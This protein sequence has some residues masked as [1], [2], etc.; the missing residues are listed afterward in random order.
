MNILILDDELD[1]MSLFLQRLRGFADNVI[2]FGSI[3]AAQQY[4]D[5]HFMLIDLFLIDETLD[6]ASDGP[7]ERSGSLFGKSIAEKYPYIPLILYTGTSYN[8]MLAKEIWAKYGF[9]YIVDKGHF[10]EDIKGHLDEFSRFVNINQQWKYREERR[11]EA[12]LRYFTK[13]TPEERRKFK[14]EAEKYAPDW[15]QFQIKCDDVEFSLANLLKSPIIEQDATERIDEYLRRTRRKYAF[16]GD[17]CGTTIETKLEKYLDLP[18]RQYKKECEQLNQDAFQYLINVL[19][20]K[21]KTEEL[22]EACPPLELNDTNKKIK[23]TNSCESEVEGWMNF[24]HKLVGRRVAFAFD[25]LTSLDKTDY[26]EKGDLYLLLRDGHTRDKKTW[27]KKTAPVFSTQLGMMSSKSTGRFI[28]ESDVDFYILHEEEL[29]I[30]Q[31]ARP[32]K[33]IAEFLYHFELPPK[34]IAYQADVSDLSKFKFAILDLK[35]KIKPD[36]YQLLRRSI[37]LGSSAYVAEASHLLTHW[38]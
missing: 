32:A 22:G 19:V 33:D 14:E 11:E 2:A 27:N 5:K 15:R 20:L 18:A 6:A 24:K 34:L 23:V 28:K 12:L 37:E 21:F 13:R 9:S 35:K 10:S 31:F 3:E 16:T 17:W 30:Q 26:F 25:E 4:I 8:L 7:F 36:E 1:T 29:W 38:L